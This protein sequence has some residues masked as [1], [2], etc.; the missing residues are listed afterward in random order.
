MDNDRIAKATRSSADIWGKSP[1]W[2]CLGSKECVRIHLHL[3]RENGLQRISTAS[4][5]TLGV[6]EVTSCDQKCIVDSIDKKLLKNRTARVLSCREDAAQCPSDQHADGRG[7]HQVYFIIHRSSSFEGNSTTYDVCCRTR[8]QVC[9]ENDE[10]SSSGLSSSA[11]Y[12]QQRA[13]V[14]EVK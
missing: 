11:T 12:F 7:Y 6:D 8:R 5:H 2:L 9:E 10:N 3:D 13:I 4:R 1:F 14:E